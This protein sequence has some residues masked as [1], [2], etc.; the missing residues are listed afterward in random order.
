MDT[1]AVK[2]AALMKGSDYESAWNSPAIGQLVASLELYSPPR[3]KATEAV[4]D[5]S[6]IANT[7]D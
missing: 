5:E 2:G 1:S 6:V 7:C 3:L 4:L